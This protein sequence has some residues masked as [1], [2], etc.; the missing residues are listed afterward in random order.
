MFFR[1]KKET[2]NT[3]W[4]PVDKTSQCQQHPTPPLHH[5]H[6]HHHNP[7]FISYI[8][9]PNIWHQGKAY[10]LHPWRET[11]L[12]FSSFLSKPLTNSYGGGGNRGRFYTWRCTV[13][14]RMTPALRW[15]AM[16]AILILHLLWGTNSQECTQTTTFKKKRQP[17]R[18][19]TERLTDRP[20]R[21]TECCTFFL[22][23]ELYVHRNHKAY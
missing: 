20:N 16:R 22:S 23:Q 3:R 17:K 11:T 19:Q 2:L 8:W 10:I 4:V 7:S 6:Y 13:T 1:K 15:A 9:I 21:L 5:H 12:C 18:F 14:P